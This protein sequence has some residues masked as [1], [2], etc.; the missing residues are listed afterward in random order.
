N[1]SGSGNAFWNLSSNFA[2]YLAASSGSVGPC[3]A[4]D[5]VGHEM[6]HG[7]GDENA[8]LVYTGEA[9]MLHESLGDINGT[10]L[11]WYF[12]STKFNWLLGD[13]VWSG[14]IR[15]MQNPKSFKHPDTYKGQFFP[16]G[17]H[18]SGGVQNYWFYLMVM[19]DTGTNDNNYNY[20]LSGLGF[21]KAI[22]IM[23]RAIFY[24]WTANTTFADANK[25]ALQAAKD[26][27]GSCSPEL[28]Y[29]YDAWKAVGLEDTSFNI[30]NLEHQIVAPDVVCSVLPDTFRLSSKGDVNRT[31]TWYFDNG[32]SANTFATNYIATRTGEHY[33][34]MR[35]EICSQVFWDTAKVVVTYQPIAKF[36]V[37]DPNACYDGK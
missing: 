12:D 11:E 26:L 22:Q 33:I 31:V 25:H 13:K 17:C 37:D 36:S 35:T 24:Y 7:V 6:G 8:G 21:E 15:N 28:A 34:L 32:D 1:L 16:N 3:A 18:G 19:G 5:V 9:C 4:I 20:Q 10:L 30:V 2:T 23:Y 14:G 29:T 27:Y